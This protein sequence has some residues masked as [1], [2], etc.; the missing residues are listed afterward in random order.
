M[1]WGADV[2]IGGRSRE[3]A[4]FVSAALYEGFSEPLAYDFGC[5][6]AQISLSTE[7]SLGSEIVIG[8]LTNADVSVIMMHPQSDSKEM[9]PAATHQ[10]REHSLDLTGF[11]NLPGLI[12]EATPHQIPLEGVGKIGERC[13]GIVHLKTPVSLAQLDTKG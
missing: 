8:R 5:K 11:Q 7:L 13:I 1:K 10:L 3:G 9:L 4:P 6:L 12:R 2:V